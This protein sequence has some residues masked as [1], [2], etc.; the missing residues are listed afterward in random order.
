MR[1]IKKGPARPALKPNEGCITFNCTTCN[2]T[3]I[4]TAKIRPSNENHNPPRGFEQRTCIGI[5]W[6]K[7]LYLASMPSE[8]FD[9]ED[10]INALYLQKSTTIPIIAGQLELECELKVLAQFIKVKRD[11]DPQHW[12][13][14]Q[15]TG[16]R[17]N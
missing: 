5:G 4:M 13:Y 8:L 1:K 16:R 2:A 3:G 15:Y 9:K 6:D 17:E 14:P 7:Q 10:E 11:L 12:R